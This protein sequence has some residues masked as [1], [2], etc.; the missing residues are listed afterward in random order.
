MNDRTKHML[1]NLLL[2]VFIF[3]VVLWVVVPIVV[4]ALY[5]FSSRLDY[6]NM[7]KVIPTHYTLKWVK[8]ILFV[9]GAWQ[10]I[11]N[12]IVVALLTILISFVLGVPA[13]YAIAKYLFPGKDSI[14]LSIIALRMFPI[15]VMAIPL[16]VLYI[17]IHLYDT[18]IGVA[19]AHTAM[20][21]PFVVL[22]TS[23]IFAGV[24]KELEEAG[25]VFGLTRFQ[26]FLKITLPL[27]LPGLAA[28]AMFT[29]VMSWNEVF[30]ASI[31]TLKHRTLPAQILSI[32]AGSSGGAA[33]PY[34]KFAAAFIMIMPALVFIF[35]ARKYLVTMWGITIK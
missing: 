9:L 23:S 25:M 19:L 4:S 17:K 35:F 20:A 34:Y 5:A 24:S 26:S 16:V 22:I 8:T 7:H 6:Y 29:F 28:A 1:R 33:P 30:V 12:S 21:L 32:M 3:T 14:K 27:A 2:Y 18:L 11:K 15:P 10:G 13:G 31:L